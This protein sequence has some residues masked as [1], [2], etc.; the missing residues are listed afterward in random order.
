[1]VLLV[2]PTNSPRIGSR[3][4][5]YISIPESAANGYISFSPS[6]RS[7]LTQEEDSGPGHFLTLPLTRSGAYGRASVTWSVT[8]ITTDSD[9]LGTTAGTATI[10]NGDVQYSNTVIST[11]NMHYVR[12]TKCYALKIE[13]LSIYRLNIF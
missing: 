1:M 2:S 4:E 12:F 5:A 11:S 9:D 10:E 6:S 3:S 8:S 13:I 7:V